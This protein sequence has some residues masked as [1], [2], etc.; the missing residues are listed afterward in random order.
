MKVF[1]ITA[2][3]TGSGKTTATM[4]FLSALENSAA[5]KVGPDYIDPGLE[6]L[7]SGNPTYNLD[8]WIDGRGYLDVLDEL[9]ESYQY[10]VVEGVMGL[11][12]SGSSINLSTDYYFRKLH[13]NYVLVIDCSRTA[14]STYHIARGFLGKRCLGV[15]LNNYGTQRHLDMV[16][17]EFQRHGIRIIGSIPRTDQFFIESRNLGLHTYQEQTNLRE[18]IG[19]AI[20][21]IDMSFLEDLEEYVPSGRLKSKSIHANSGRNICVA[22]DRAFNFYYAGS[23]E[24]LQKIG[25]VSYF[26]PIKG[27]IPEDPDMIYLGGGYPELYAEELSRNAKCRNNILES[28]RSGKII[29]A[30]CGGL[31]Y[32]QNSMKTEKGTFPMAGVFDGVV[33]MDKRLTLNYTKLLARKETVMFS[34]GQILYGHEYHYSHVEGVDGMVLDN[35]QGRGID[36]KH[37]GLSTNLTQATYSHFS[38]KRYGEKIAK[39]LEKLV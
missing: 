7:V 29:I 16:S 5:V 35:L 33:E 17:G 11:Y 23:L 25:R 39:K 1:G 14:E 28:A 24:F 34:R 3:Y 20:R 38:L 2:P 31:M 37:D 22:M 13:I 9:A 8:R 10:A 18:K 21:N 19:S 36:G 26:S 15:I 30:E 6:S 32:L 27:E 12:D 4:A